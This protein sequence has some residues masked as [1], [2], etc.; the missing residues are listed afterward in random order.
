MKKL[1]I[2]ALV[3]V[4]FFS[5][6]TSDE[7]ENEVHQGQLVIQL[8]SNQR[9]LEEVEEYGLSIVNAEGEAVI[10]FDKVADAPASIDLAVG[11]YTVK[12][13]SA[14]EKP[15]FSFDAPYFY[16]EEAC[17]IESGQETSVS[18]DCKMEHVKLTLAYSSEITDNAKSYSSVIESANGQITIDEET[19]NTVYAER[20]ALIISTTIEE[21]DGTVLTG[22]QVI[23]GLENQTEYLINISY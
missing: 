13:Y 12:V 18:I 9:S 20:S 21:Q 23:S 11:S 3:S 17:V 22:K 6:T 8:S 4:L 14:E 10:V 19:S 1:F 2:T 15:P 7:K 5:C 16:G